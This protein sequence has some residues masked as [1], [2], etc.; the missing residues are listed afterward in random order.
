MVPREHREGD[1]FFCL[2]NE[3]KV[4]EV[5]KL[6]LEREVVAYLVDK[7]GELFLRGRDPGNKERKVWDYAV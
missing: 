7:G 2:E 1:T 3:Q 6:S 4:K 5:F